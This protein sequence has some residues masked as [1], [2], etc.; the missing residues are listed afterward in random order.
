MAEQPAVD[1][2][3]EPATA[4][5]EPGRRE[6]DLEPERAGEP[7]FQSESSSTTP[8]VPCASPHA[9]ITNGSFTATQ[10]MTSIRARSSWRSRHSPE[11]DVR[12][13]RGER[14]GTPNSATLRPA[15]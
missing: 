8:R 3:R 15:K 6:I 11:V 9:A 12:A 1:Q 7:P 4:A 5:A 10:A 2:R 13:G 14:P